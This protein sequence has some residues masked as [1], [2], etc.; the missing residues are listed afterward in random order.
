MKENYCIT[1]G[2]YC[3]LAGVS[4]FCTQSACTRKT[5]AI[6]T[7]GKAEPLLFTKNT[8]RAENTIP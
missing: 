8:I 7:T 2:I 6:N 1:E 5:K 4:G 3:P